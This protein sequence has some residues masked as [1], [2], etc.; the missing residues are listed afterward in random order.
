MLVIG[1]VGVS[2]LGSKR[3]V[4][5][6]SAGGRFCCGEAAALAVQGLIPARVSKVW[7]CW[8]FQAAA[9]VRLWMLPA[10]M[11]AAEGGNHH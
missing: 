10:G 4:G 8:D 11:G 2:L 6:S 3:C 7:L 1:V 5:R 9:D